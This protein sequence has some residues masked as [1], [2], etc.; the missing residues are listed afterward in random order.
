[1]SPSPGSGDRPL[2]AFDREASA[3]WSIRLAGVDEAGRGCLA[4]PVVAAAVVLDPGRIPD[5]LDDSKRLT[6]RERER[7]YTEIVKG[8]PAWSAFSVSSRRIDEVNI[9]R[10]ALQAMAGS[11]AGLRLRPDLVLVDG[12]RLPDLDRPAR[13]VVG[14]DGRSA[15]IA[16]ASI[17]AKVVRDS[18]MC[19]LDDRYP[20]YGFG[21]HKGYGSRRHITALEDLGP[22]PVHRM[23]FRPLADRNQTSLF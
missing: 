5:G 12:N 17:I 3:G 6:R 16:A 13:A 4:G 10:A 1:M 14:G 23:T 20:A 21:A 2:V 11:V 19:E 8:A 9:L 7:L 18:L 15:A 22:T